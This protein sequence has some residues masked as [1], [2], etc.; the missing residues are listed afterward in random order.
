MA[1]TSR[2]TLGRRDQPWVGGWI[3]RT[4]INV[5]KRSLRR[6]FHPSLR[7]S[8]DPDPDGLIDLWRAVASLPARQRDAVVLVYRL[9]FTTEEAARAIGCPP[10][11][12]RADLT[13]ARHALAHALKEEIDE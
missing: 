4:A 8:V 11:T 10:G 7:P 2:S 6:R 12:L 1:A 9:G 13:R 5:L 3:T